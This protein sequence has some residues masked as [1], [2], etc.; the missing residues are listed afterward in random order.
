VVL[1][2]V[3]TDTTEEV[4]QGMVFVVQLSTLLGKLY[5]SE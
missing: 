5:M 3:V 4:V 2:F 1:T